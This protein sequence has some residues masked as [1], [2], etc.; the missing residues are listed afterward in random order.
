MGK[1]DVKEE[2]LLPMIIRDEKIGDRLFHIIRDDLIPGGTKMRSL[3]WVLR[4]NPDT[5]E[6]V[7]AANTSGGGIVSLVFGCTM[8]GKKAT[9]F[10]NG[11]ENSTTAILLAQP[12]VTIHN[13]RF[14]LWEVEKL[15]EQYVHESVSKGKKVK[16]LPFGFHSLEMNT[17]FIENIKQ[18]LPMDMRLD[19]P[20]RMWLAAGSGNT[21]NCLSKIFPST[22]FLAVQIGRQIP[23]E[24]TNNCRVKLFKA[25]E[26]FS[27]PAAYLPPFPSVVTMDAKVW[28]FVLKYGQSGD[29]FWNAS[30]DI[31]KEEIRELPKLY[32]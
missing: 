15:A 6:F 5:E 24:Y 18:N 22:E 12:D 11:L 30:K 23:E 17:A 2:L 7:Y 9:L 10:L 28:S 32:R 27:E 3:N 14:K 29:Y 21:L 19:P 31:I 1:E 4:N 25:R 13:C 26:Y 20:K 16:L 8:F